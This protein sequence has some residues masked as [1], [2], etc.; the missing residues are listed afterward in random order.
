[1]VCGA[2]SG[3]RFSID[4]EGDVVPVVLKGLSAMA[5]MPNFATNRDLVAKPLENCDSVVGLQAPFGYFGV[6]L[7]SDGGIDLG[8]LVHD[9]D[10]FVACC[11]SA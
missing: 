9:G 1:V 10:M 3:G 8:D 6:R 11:V 4:A 7:R 2:R 5:D